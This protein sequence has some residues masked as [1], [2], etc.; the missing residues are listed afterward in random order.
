[1]REDLQFRS[2]GN[3]SFASSRHYP[4][5]FAPRRFR[6]RSE[7]LQISRAG[8]AG[9]AEFAWIARLRMGFAGLNTASAPVIRSR[10]RRDA[11]GGSH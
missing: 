9:T 3:G 10:E 8:S 7:V 5:D 2:R 4:E 6:Q 11:S 1:M